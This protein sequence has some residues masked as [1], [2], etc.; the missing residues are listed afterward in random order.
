MID[1]NK[2][3]PQWFSRL[4]NKKS[5]D[6]NTHTR[7]GTISEDQQLASKLRELITRKFKKRKLHPSYQDNIL[8]DVLAD[9]LLI[10]KIQ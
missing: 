2:G 8:G 9:M 10:K 7:T 3:L 1:T 6:T 5:I 4:F